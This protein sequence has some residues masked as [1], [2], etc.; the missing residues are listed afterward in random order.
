MKEEVK[1]LGSLAKMKNMIE[2]NRLQQEAQR[3]RAKE[4]QFNNLLQPYQEQI[5]ELID[6]VEKKVKE[7][8]ASKSVIDNIE[9]SMISQVMLKVAQD[10]IEAMDKDVEGLKERSART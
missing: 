4:I 3:I 2:M 6:A 5:T 8:T 7:F 1:I 9:D 10:Y